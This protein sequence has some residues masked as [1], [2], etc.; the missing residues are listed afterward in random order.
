MVEEIKTLE[1]R[2]I[3]LL[4]MGKTQG[5]ITYE[6]LAEQLKGLEVDSDTLDELYNFLIENNIEIVTEDG[7]D[8][9]SGEEITTDMS[10]ENLTL[11]KDVKINDPVRMYLKEIGRINLLTSDEEFEY[12]QRAE[13]GDEEAKRILA[14]SNLRLVVSIAKRYVGRGMLFLD[15][16]QEGNIGLMKAV[17][18][19]NPELEFRFSTY[20][21]W[22]IRQNIVRVMADEGRNI[23]I[24]VHAIEQYGYIKRA[25]N[26]LD[27]DNNN[28]PSYEDIAN[29]INKKGW[30]VSNKNRAIT[31][32][33]IKRYMST[34]ANTDTISL[35]TPIGEE[36]DS[37]IGDFIADDTINIERITDN[38]DLHDRVSFIVHNYLTER[39][40]NVLICRFGLDGGSPM[41][42]EQIAQQYGLT[43]ER[44]R[45]IEEKAKRKVKRRALMSGLYKDF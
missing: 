21:T 8:D 45:Q 39:E 5:F 44:I 26:I 7:S 1:E 11:S 40:A 2:K 32:E 16:I 23:R 36:D 25:I 43:R 30:I 4:E 6:Q 20:A 3:K 42:L 22:W 29:L 14:E 12:A 18:K 15:L 27:T 41:T 34:Y 19:F 10:V 9:A 28:P 13:Q 24:P 38:T 17:D 37:L 35:Q 31:P 33:E